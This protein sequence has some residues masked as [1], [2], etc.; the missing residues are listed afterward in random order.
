MPHPP[1]FGQSGPISVTVNGAPVT[2]DVPPMMTQGN[3]YVPLRGV[4]EQ[5]GATVTFDRASGMINATRGTTTVQ[6][7]VGS[8]LAKVDGETMFML[9]P[10]LYTRGRTLVPLR[11]VSQALGATVDWNPVRREVDI[12][13]EVAPKKQKP[14]PPGVPGGNRGH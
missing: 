5:I 13:A 2:F 3:V 9:Q 7:S 11:F 14:G 8:K 12:T 1:T 6:L 10:A 4:F